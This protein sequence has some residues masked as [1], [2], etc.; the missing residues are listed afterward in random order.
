MKFAGYL[1]WKMYVTCPFSQEEFLISCDLEKQ[2]VKKRERLQCKHNWFWS[3]F[4]VTVKRFKKSCWNS[5]LLYVSI[6]LRRGGNWPLRACG[7][8]CFL[9]SFSCERQQSHLFYEGLLELCAVQLLW[10]IE[11]EWPLWYFVVAIKLFSYCSRYRIN[12]LKSPKKLTPR[13]K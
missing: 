5:P 7:D 12:K 8:P 2:A 1:L 3:G 4:V 10:G 13:K 6:V 9:H 11:W